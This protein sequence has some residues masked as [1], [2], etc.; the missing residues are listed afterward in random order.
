LQLAAP[1]A[2]GAATKVSAMGS[3]LKIG[4]SKSWYGSYLDEFEIRR[5]KAL[6]PDK[7]S[8]QQMLAALE[9][10][11]ERR[12]A[13]LVDTFTDNQRVPIETH[14]VA[15]ETH[16]KVKGNSP[17]YIKETLHSIRLVCSAQQ[18]VFL[19]DITTERLECF[20]AEKHGAGMSPRTVNSYLVALKVFTAW[21]DR[22]GRVRQNP[23]KHL[24]KR[25]E[26][27]DQRRPRRTLSP[28]DFTKLIKYTETAEPLR[29]LSGLD[30]AM[31]Y[32]VAVATGLRAGELASLTTSSL[33]LE[34][35][36]PLI[37]LEAAYS[38]R[39]RR[40]EQPLPSWLVDKLNR[41][42]ATRPQRLRVF[43]DGKLWPGGWA[44]HAAKIMRTDLEGAGLD[45]R[46]EA[47]E[48]FDFHAL[49]HQFITT[50]VEMNLHPKTTQTLARHSTIQLT[51]DRYTHLRTSDVAQ[52]VDAMEDPTRRPAANQ[53]RMTGTYDAAPA[54]RD[55]ANSCA[56]PAISGHSLAVSGR[57]GEREKIA[58]G[59][60]QREAT[61][62]VTRAEGTGLEPATACAAPEFQT[63]AVDCATTLPLATSVESLPHGCANSARV[64]AP[65]GRSW[66]ENELPI[67]LQALRASLLALPLADRQFLSAELD[68]SL[69]G[70]GG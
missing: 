66:P 42:L 52:S 22:T 28:E 62:R 10:T 68:R 43:D 40:D 13:G 38:K 61:Q 41:W 6:S 17:R 47:G 20:L 67:H 33:S 35:S 54:P 49:R 70:G 19:S 7:A 3:L 37:V 53:E 57:N 45:Y 25:N 63:G 8:A 31:L 44:R 29:R 32:S 11:V 36:P 16:L 56:Q 55:C 9:L 12:K 1:P 15:F 64:V 26:A 46:D 18:M 39:R 24:E 30:R 34:G 69:K 60:A 4:A 2:A 50:L 51:M 14:L 5:R 65:H 27:V 23:L 59:R 48:V 21:C 58:L